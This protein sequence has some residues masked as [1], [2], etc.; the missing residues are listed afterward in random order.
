MREF[1]HRIFQFFF[2]PI[3]FHPSLNV[4]TVM[5]ATA[6]LK[7]PKTKCQ[8]LTPFMLPREEKFGY[9]IGRVSLAKFP[10][11]HG[12]L[13]RARDLHERRRDGAGVLGRLSHELFRPF[14]RRRVRTIYVRCRV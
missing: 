5:P 14:G 10:V 3:H 4:M 1:S 13:F 7:V 11:A 8:A 9:H 12:E 2:L 6:R